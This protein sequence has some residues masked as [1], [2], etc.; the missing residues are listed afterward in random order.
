MAPMLSVL[1]G[2][3]RGG[4]L[5]SSAPTARVLVVNDHPLIRQAVAEILGG[6]AG[7]MHV[8]Q[9]ETVAAALAELAAHP[10]TSLV[11]L[12]PALGTAPARAGSS[13]FARS[14][15]RRGSLPC[16]RRPD[17]PPCSRRSR[18]ARWASSPTARRPACC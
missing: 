2:P 16:A 4:A 6:L 3:Q 12:D 8:I 7:G 17:A 9:A 11:L 13:A 18:A 14:I 10:E 1:P 15:P 5:L